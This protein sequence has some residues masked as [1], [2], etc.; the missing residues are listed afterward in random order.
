MNLKLTLTG[1]CM[2]VLCSMPAIAQ[3][4]ETTPMDELAQRTGNLESAVEALKKVKITGYVQFQYQ[5]GE[6]DAALKVGSGNE[7]SD[8]AFNR[9][10]IRRGRIKLA[11]DDAITGAVFQLDVNEKDGVTFRDAY[12]TAKDPWGGMSG[13]KFGVFDR[14]FGFEISYSSSRRESPERSTIFT[15]LFPQERDLGGQLTLQAGK[16][17]PFNFLKIDAGLF[18]GNGIKP[19]IDSRRDFIGHAS[20]ANAV[21]SDIKIGVGASYYNGYVYQGSTK[22]YTMKGKEFVLYDDEANKG[23]FAKREYFGADAQLGFVTFM[24][25]T[26]LRGE[27]LTGQQPGLE[28]STKSPN[29]SSLP[30][31]TAHTYI[32]K[33]EGGYVM[34]I[35]DLGRLPFS[36]VAKYD[37]YDPNTAVSKDET[38]LGGTGKA[39]LFQETLGLGLLWRINNYLR[40]Q[41]Y[42]EINRFEKSAN[43][44]SMDNYQGNVLT[45]RIQQKF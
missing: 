16:T 41:G 27:Y 25:M 38:G 1:L 37:W 32:R 21:G 18:A 6:K 33:F 35:Q 22:V 29:S 19:E 11:Y 20:A 3:E 23:A 31:I 24:G 44:A 15:T 13:L 40:V 8:K 10:G 42:Y 26:Q 9:I 39:D 36:A 4:T 12:L 14:P 28:G 7:N 34:F 17:S 45:I 5:H 30:G 43:V 2:A